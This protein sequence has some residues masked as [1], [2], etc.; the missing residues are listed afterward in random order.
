MPA[1][2][3]VMSPIT[4][5]VVARMSHAAKLPGSINIATD[6]AIDAAYVVIAV[7]YIETIDC[8]S[9]YHLQLNDTTCKKIGRL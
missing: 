4:D 3:T 9:K 6:A 1:S 7:E 5:R 8:G 2:M